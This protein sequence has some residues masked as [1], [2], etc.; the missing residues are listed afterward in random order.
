MEIINCKGC[1]NNNQ[2][3]QI[4]IESNGYCNYCNKFKKNF[5]PML[6]EKEFEEFKKIAKN[7]P[8]SLAYSGG[9]DSTVA[10]YK[11]IHDFG[12]KPKLFFIDVCYAPK[13]VRENAVKLAEYFGLDLDIIQQAPYYDEEIISKF[14]QLSEII[15][16]KYSN[17]DELRKYYS[18]G[19]GF[20]RPCWVCIK[21]REKMFFDITIKQGSNNLVL[22]YNEWA[23]LEPR[24]SGIREIKKNNKNVK[25]FHLPFLMRLKMKDVEETLKKIPIFKEINLESG[26]KDCLLSRY[27]ET[28]LNNTLGFH[29]DSLRL[30]A[31]TMV[32]FLTKEEAKIALSKRWPDESNKIPDLVN[33][34]LNE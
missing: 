3:P 23:Q 18:G 10:L 24:V 14:K 6:I 27:V 26:S 9:K 13:R 21:A 4:E 7:G 17:S 12:I 11:L 1:I 31:E 2:N 34:I 28:K 19:N 16:K 8:I 15:P 30:A 22:A 5:D 33:E 29:P 32:G 20:I 25:I